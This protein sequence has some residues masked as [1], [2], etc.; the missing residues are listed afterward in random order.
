MN[1]WQEQQIID[2]LTIVVDKWCCIEDD[3]NSILPE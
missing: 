2:K 1:R 3:I